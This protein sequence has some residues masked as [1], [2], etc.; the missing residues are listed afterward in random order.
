MSAMSDHSEP[1][2]PTTPHPSEY[3]VPD[4]PGPPLPYYPPRPRRQKWPWL[5]AAG[6]LVVVGSVTG[7]G[8]AAG[9][10]TNYVLN[11]MG[12]ELEVLEVLSRD[13]DLMV[14]DAHCPDAQPITPGHS[15]TCSIRLSGEPDLRQ[16][17]ITV[18]DKD[19][20]Y[21]V[22]RPTG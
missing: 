15:F 1:P 14:S 11:S 5:A 22:S 3:A 8:A 13:Y 20:N 2:R 21:T 19:G 10:F 7:I 16:V 17:T 6:A 12:V 4:D 18:Q 9:W